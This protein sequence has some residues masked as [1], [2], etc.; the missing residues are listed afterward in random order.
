AGSLYDVLPFGRGE[1]PDQDRTPPGKELYQIV[2]DTSFEKY[3]VRPRKHHSLDQAPEN[4]GLG[5]QQSPVL[6]RASH[7]ECV[8]VVHG[9]SLQGNSELSLDEEKFAVAQLLR[10]REVHRLPQK[11]EAVEG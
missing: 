8:L 6:F 4:L 5:G 10:H 3:H 11:G 1:S 7:A 9:S 2:L